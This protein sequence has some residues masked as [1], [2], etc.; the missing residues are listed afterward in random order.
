MNLN[1]YI[2]I[3]YDEL[4]Q[5]TR[6]IT[7]NNELWDELFHFCLE[8]VLTYDTDK[9]NT[10]LD[11]G[12]LKYF[13]VSILL[14]QWNSS[15]S[16]FYKVY[17]KDKFSDIDDTID[18]AAEEY[19][20][21]IDEKIDYIEHKLNNEHWYVQK[22]IEMKKDLSYGQISEITKIPRSSLFN[23]VNKFRKEIKEEYGRK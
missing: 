12:H 17:R 2:T 20:F 3:N 11:K 13:F 1:E 9:I 14:R 23:T 6:N 19:D 8:I 7:K 21:E 5:I 10:I 16:P 18:I 15:T 4:K 22:V